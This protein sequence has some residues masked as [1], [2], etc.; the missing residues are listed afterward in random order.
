MSPTP[1][2]VVRAGTVVAT[3]LLSTLISTCGHDRPRARNLIVICI[4][5]LRADR[6]SS[7][8]HYRP[9]TPVLD[10]L[11]SQGALFEQAQA[12]SNWTVPSVASLLT[13]RY[14]NRHGAIVP[15]EIKHLGKSPK[16]PNEISRDV[17]LL[18]EILGGAGFATALFSGNPYLYGRFQDGFQEVH[19]RSVDAEAHLPRILEWLELERERKFFLYW[20]IMDLHQPLDPP[21]HAGTRFVPDPPPGFPGDVHRGWTFGNLRDADDPEFRRYAELR[22]ALYDGALGHVDGLIG[23]LLARLDVLGLLEETLVVVVSDHGEEF[24]DHWEVQAARGDDPRGIWGIG[25]GHTMYQELLRVPL[26]LTGPG[27]EPGRRVRCPVSLVDLFAT[28]LARLHL[29]QLETDGRDLSRWL[30]ARPGECRERP[31]VSGAPAYGRDSGAVRLGAL[32]LAWR[33]GGAPELY[34]LAADPG[35]RHDLASRRP[36]DLERILA[37]LRESD[38]G[39]AVETESRRLSDELVDELRALGY[40]Q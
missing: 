14:P 3:I 31:L 34:D 39:R 16:A 9:T 18:A 23:R 28:A 37:A 25:H 17:P 13:G 29:P 5:T 8:G 30:G 32:K 7:Y 19:V 24:W 4:D 33:D 35:E 20:Q 26:I 27:V 12:T 36:E 22:G 6:L 38:S 21:A 2:V 11:A 10:R 40:L 1:S 15:G